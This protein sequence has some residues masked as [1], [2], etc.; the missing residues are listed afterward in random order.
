MIGSVIAMEPADF[1]GWLGSGRA[2]ES[3]VAV[4]EKLFQDHACSACHQRAAQPRGPALAGLFG[5][6]VELQSGQTVV[7]DEAYIRESIVRPQAKVVAGFEPMMP[8][9]Q[10]L[11]TEEQLQQLI[12]YVRSLGTEEQIR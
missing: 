11:L 5:R 9:Y 12:A 7:A 1:Q 3:P 8:T 2:W 10:G 4:G 6:S